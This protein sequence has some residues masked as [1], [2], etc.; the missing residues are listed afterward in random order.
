MSRLFCIMQLLHEA[1]VFLDSRDAKRLSLG[2][3]SVNKIVVRYG[4]CAD[5]TLDI[6]GIA[7]CDSLVDALQR[8]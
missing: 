4:C 1:R 2:A 8:N 6:R 7:E 5:S 3:D